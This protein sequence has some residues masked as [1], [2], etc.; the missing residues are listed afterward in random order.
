MYLMIWA[1]NLKW[2]G[3]FLNL[4]N[5]SMDCVEL[6]VKSRCGRVDKVWKF[7]FQTGNVSDVAFR[8]G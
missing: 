4:S 6:F 5:L 1:A 7:D 3:F 8:V 2:G